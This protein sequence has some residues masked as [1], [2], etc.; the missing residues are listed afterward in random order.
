ME[1][2][3]A[4]HL[5]LDRDTAGQNCTRYALSLNQKYQ[6]RGSLYAPYKDVN[7]WM[8]HIGKALKPSQ[9]FKSQKHS[10]KR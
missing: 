2:H 7:E 9:D 6:D 5:Y 3:D 10:I 4:I 1:R 8:M